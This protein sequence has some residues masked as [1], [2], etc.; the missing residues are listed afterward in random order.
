MSNQGPPERDF[1]QSEAYQIMEDAFQEN[2][3]YLDDFPGFESRG[4]STSV[5]ENPDRSE[6]G[7]VRIEITYRF[8]SEDSDSDLVRH[9]YFEALEKAWDEAGYD[10][11]R[12][13]ISDDGEVKDVEARRPDGVNYWFRVWDRVVLTIQSGC[14]RET[15][16]DEPYIPPVGD[17]PPENDRTHAEQRGHDPDAEDTPTE[18]ESADAI[19]PFAN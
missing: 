18:D 5:C 8:S 12:V 7:F 10:I 4:Y 9:D 11:H 16:I 13:D 15:G 19:N 3:E 1:D 14:V 6:T 17:V 2:I